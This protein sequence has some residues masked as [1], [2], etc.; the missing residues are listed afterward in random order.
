MKSR[1]AFVLR[2]CAAPVLALAVIFCGGASRLQAQVASSSQVV[3][4]R[5]ATGSGSVVREMMMRLHAGGENPEMSTRYT[6]LE[7]DHPQR[8]AQL[9]LQSC[10]K[11]RI[12]AQIEAQRVHVVTRPGLYGIGAAPAGSSYGVVDGKLVRFDPETMRIQSVV[13][14]VDRILD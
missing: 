5:Q 11:M 4:P 1:P 12:G 10:K 6:M 7:A 3:A 8:E 14:M 13:R 2:L 9:S